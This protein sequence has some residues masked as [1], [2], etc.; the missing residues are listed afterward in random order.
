MLN[1]IIILTDGVSYGNTGAY[2]PRILEQFRKK[3]PKDRRMQFTC[4]SVSEVSKKYFYL[5]ETLES[6]K[7]I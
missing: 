2:G 3:C 1:R 5:R 6:L 4:Y 7:W